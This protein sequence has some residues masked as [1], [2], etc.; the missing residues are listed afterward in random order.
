MSFLSLVRS[1]RF[2]RLTKEGGWILFGQI[3]TILGSVVAVR[4][5][6]EL[7][8]PIEYGELAL[9]LTFAT[10]VNQTL[11]GP[12]VNGVSRYY[13][14]AVERNDVNGYLKS[15]KKLVK[16]GSWGIIGFAGVSALTLFAI[17]KVTWVPIVVLALI[18]SIVSGCSSI[19][20]GMQNAAR[21]RAIV[22]TH[23]GIEPWLRA[24]FMCLLVFFLGATSPTAI[25]AYAVAVTLVLISQMF[26]FSKT[27]SHVPGASIPADEW[28][29]R[30]L[31]FSYPF[32]IF[33]I[34]TWAQLVSDR[35][36]L[37]LFSDKQSV[38]LYAVLFQLGYYPIT[39]ASGMAVQLLAPIFFQKAGDGKNTE[40][41]AEID[42]LSF[43]LLGISLLITGIFVLFA[44]FFHEQVFFLLASRSYSS[45]SHLL[46]WV[47]L[48]GGLFASGETVGLNIFSKF[49]TNKLI[50]PKIAT[51]ILGVVLNLIGAYFWGIAGIVG[52]NT[53]FSATYLVYMI[54]VARRIVVQHL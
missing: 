16:T 2:K 18:F 10:L 29:R 5:T 41:M 37:Q 21:Q 31:L 23:R 45:T 44:F 53:V 43:R 38:G 22:A 3:A 20:G 1:D 35:W 12:L 8:S 40:R 49:A 47:L 33:G 54:Y 52:A 34:F 13:S 11:L 51:A 50:V 30:I 25:F 32:S 14:P 24:L 36:A 4:V 42:K 48:A 15:V 19:L 26:F 39:I 6:T 27:I 9:G 7:L 46:P 28:Q 17:G